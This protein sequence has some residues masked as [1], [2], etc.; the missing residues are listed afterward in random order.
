MAYGP[1]C[2]TL[3]DRTPRTRR[4]NSLTAFSATRDLALES[5]GAGAG[6]LPVPRRSAGGSGPSIGRIGPR[7]SGP[8][9]AFGEEPAKEGAGSHL[10]RRARSAPRLSTAGTH[11][12]VPQDVAVARDRGAHLERSLGLASGGRSRASIWGIC[13]C[14]SVLR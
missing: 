2:M 6:P 12:S 5:L 7:P 10:V 13:G 14:E 4:R 8:P 3:V 9:P 1:C 11:P